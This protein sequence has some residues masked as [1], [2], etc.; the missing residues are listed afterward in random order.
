MMH[1]VSNKP[2]YRGR[3]YNVSFS[4][5]LTDGPRVFDPARLSLNGIIIA[6]NAGALSGCYTLG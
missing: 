5:Y 6:S 1:S 4:L 3:I 2:C